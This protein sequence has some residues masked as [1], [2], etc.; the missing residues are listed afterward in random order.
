MSSR[1]CSP[2]RFVARK[3]LL[4]LGYSTP[5]DGAAE[6]K[7]PRNCPTCG[8]DLG[9]IRPG[10]EAIC[11]ACRRTGHDAELAY[12]LALERGRAR[13]ATPRFRPR[14]SRD[15]GLQATHEQ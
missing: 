6:S 2:S 7:S 13:A 3:Q 4:T 15:P 10:S 14:V 5:W 8:G 1:P 9:P 11:L 12:D